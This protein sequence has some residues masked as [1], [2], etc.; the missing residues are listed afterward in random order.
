[1]YEDA[2]FTHCYKIPTQDPQLGGYIEVTAAGGQKHGCAK[3]LT[4]D[5]GEVGLLT[6]RSVNLEEIG[7]ELRSPSPNKYLTII[8]DSSDNINSNPPPVPSRKRLVK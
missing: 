1:M 4:T 3:S 7:E 6:A 8:R 2:D 5:D